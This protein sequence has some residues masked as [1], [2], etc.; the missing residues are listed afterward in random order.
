D[1]RPRLRLDPHGPHLRTLTQPALTADG[2][3]AAATRITGL[4]ASTLIHPRY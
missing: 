1:A 2:R 3:A 4:P